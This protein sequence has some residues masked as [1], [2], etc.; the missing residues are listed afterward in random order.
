MTT[1]A[2]TELPMISWERGQRLDFVDH[3]TTYIAHGT[4][5]FGNKYS[6]TWESTCGEVEIKDIY[7]L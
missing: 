7:K 1:L 5:H 2:T 4:D 6:G 3:T